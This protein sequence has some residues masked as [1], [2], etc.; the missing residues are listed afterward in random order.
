M[1][2][3]RIGWTDYS[4]GD[5]NFVW[6]GSA[7]IDCKVSAGCAHCYVDRI[8]A[9]LGDKWPK[10][11]TV[12]PDKLARLLNKHP[13]PG[14]EPYRRGPGAKPMVFVC[15]TG[16]LFHT[17][18]PDKFV[19]K[20]LDGFRARHDITWQVLTKR[21][22]RM[23]H[24][25]T[26]Y[27]NAR[28]I[29]NLPDHIWLG[30]TAENQ[31][32]LNLRYRQL[33]RTPAEVKWLSIEPMLGPVD[34]SRLNFRRG[35]DWIVV[36]GESGPEAAPMHPD[37]VRAVRDVCVQEG[38]SF[39]FKQWGEWRHADSPEQIIEWFKDGIVE[40]RQVEGSPLCL[41]RVGRKE[42]G[43]VLDGVTWHEFPL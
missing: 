21:A 13:T 6:R 41:Y 37:W 34:F 4:G 33:E 9:R 2:R 27:C 26:A 19:F 8:I 35:P 38:L 22:Q 36:G 31:H 1:K 29:Y 42:A 25:V 43:D 20:A 23:F 11:T 24:T 39:F 14:D 32:W 5:A 16:D 15:D 17:D 28:N 40:M 30:V 12:Y 18:V 3:S 7:A 10:Y